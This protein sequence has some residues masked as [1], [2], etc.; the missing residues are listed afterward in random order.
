MPSKS[1]NKAI[2]ALIIANI[3]WGA[4]SPIFK[5][6]LYN[7]PLFTFAFLRFFFGSF[8]LLPFALAG[9]IAI[10][11]KDFPLIIL[12]SITIFLHIT[13]YFLGLKYAPSINAPIIASSGPI[14]MIILSIRLLHEHPRH[15]V[16][17]GTI[18]SLLGVLVIIFRSCMEIANGS[19][20]IM[21]NLFTVLA[22][23]SAIIHVVLC[24]KILHKYSALLVTWWY[25]FLMSIGFIP[26]MIYEIK[27]VGFLPNLNIAGMVGILFGIVFASFIGHALYIWGISKIKAAEIGIFSYIDPVAAIIIAIPLLGE[28]ITFSYLLGSLLV[29]LGIFIAEGRLHYHPIHKLTKE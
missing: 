3:I 20:E 10:K 21:G 1:H 24:K 27:T 26:F 9:G 7:V 4:A 15:K 22:T 29:F 11:R 12:I 19:A 25:F 18:L 13:F 23:I 16:I 2:L 8:L 28:K 17:T 6:T 5:W 14:L